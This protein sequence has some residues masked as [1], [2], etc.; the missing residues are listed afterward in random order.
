MDSCLTRFQSSSTLQ[1]VIAHHSFSLSNIWLYGYL[2]FCLSTHQWLFGLFPALGYNASINNCAPTPSSCVDR[3]N[4]SQIL[5]IHVWIHTHTHTHTGVEL[6]GDTFQPFK[7]PSNFS[8]TDKY[9][10]L[11][12]HCTGVRFLFFLTNTCDCVPFWLNRLVDK[13][14]C[15]MNSDLHFPND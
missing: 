15:I 13:E 6:L 5:Y 10:I 12:Q 3:L 11:Y 8:T 9:F 14:Y 1:C 4:F 2:T 7:E